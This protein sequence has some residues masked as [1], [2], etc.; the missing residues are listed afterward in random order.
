MATCSSVT[1]GKW[2]PTA[3]YIDRINRIFF[4]VF[5]DSS[6]IYSMNPVNPVKSMV[7]IAFLPRLT[8]ASLK[9]S[10]GDHAK[11]HKT[12][13]PDQD[14]ED[15]EKVGGRIRSN[16]IGVDSQITDRSSFDESLLLLPRYDNLVSIADSPNQPERIHA[17]THVIQNVPLLI[18]SLYSETEFAIVGSKCNVSGYSA[19]ALRLRHA[20]WPFSVKGLS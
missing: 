2:P 15:E 1:T 6:V 14:E 17:D 18:G 20:G 9:K 4:V 12:T 19:V 5:F 7:T 8:K 10:Y 13:Q 3:L 11:N 16:D